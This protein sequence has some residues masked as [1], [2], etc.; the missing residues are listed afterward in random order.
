MIHETWGQWPIFVV[1]TSLPFTA[2]IFSTQPQHSTQSAQ[3]WWCSDLHGTRLHLHLLVQ[4]QHYHDNICFRL[5]LS[6][7][8][9]LGASSDMCMVSWLYV[10]AHQVANTGI[11]RIYYWKVKISQIY[12]MLCIL[13]L[14]QVWCRVH[15]KHIQYIQCHMIIKR[16]SICILYF[17]SIQ[18]KDTMDYI[19]QI[20]LT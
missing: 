9:Q 1:F 8:W 11:G 18:L 16:I 10:G 15:I 5:Q 12:F 3:L 19:N 17:K 13:Q 7:S 4:H 20:L 2:N 14:L 6:P